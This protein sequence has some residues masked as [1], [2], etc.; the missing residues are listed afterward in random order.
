MEI[1]RLSLEGLLLISPSV[2]EDERGSFHES[3]NE[4]IYEEI[5]LP[6]FVQDNESFSTI[7][8]LRG[9]HYQLPPYGQGKLVRVTQGS[10]LDVVVDLRP[11]S[12]TFGQ[13]KS[14]EITAESK[15][16]L[17]I[18]EGFAHGFL[19]L[20]DEVTFNYKCTNFYNK[21]SERSI[22]WKDAQLGIDWGMSKALVSKKD[23]NAAT[24]AEAITEIKELEVW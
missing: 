16:Q 10:V 9:L 11:S 12:S 3:Y 23:E 4:K 7:N 6:K 20:T 17:W 22:F 5:G 19:T 14:V 18:P 2:F 8:V 13:Y 15:N 24:Y 1:N 21:E